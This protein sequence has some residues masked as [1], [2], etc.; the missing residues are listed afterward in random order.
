M[1]ELTP[2]ITIG[3]SSFERPECAER[4]VRSIRT[5][6]RCPIIIA[7]DSSNEVHEQLRETLQPVEGLTLLRA[8]YDSGL[9]VKRNLI[10]RTTITELLCLC[11]DDFIFTE[12]TD[13]KLLITAIESGNDLAAG[14]VGSTTPYCHTFTQRGTVMFEEPVDPATA[15]TWAGYTQY[16]LLLNFFVARVAA[17]EAV[18]WDPPLKMHE[19]GD[20]FMR[21][22]HLRKT[23]VP[24][25]LVDHVR[26]APGDYSE[27]RA[28]KVVNCLDIRM[29]RLL[30]RGLTH[31]VS[32]NGTRIMPVRRI[33]PRPPDR[34]APFQHVVARAA[35][36]NPLGPRPRGPIEA[37]PRG[38]APRFDKPKSPPPTPVYAP[39]KVS[40][41]P[42]A[43]RWI[44]VPNGTDAS[45]APD[46]VP[47]RLATLLRGR[48]AIVVG[49]APHAV[50]PDW[51]ENDIVITAN[52]G[53]CHVPEW[54]TVVAVITPNLLGL[55][56]DNF[57]ADA[58]AVG[59]YAGRRVEHLVIVGGGWND[60]HDP[61]AHTWYERA[62]HDAWPLEDI[63][64]T[65]VHR[66]I[67]LTPTGR[68]RVMA[69][70]TG[71]RVIH[72]AIHPRNPK[73]WTWQANG[74]S[75][76]IV[77]AA[78]AHA[79]GARSVILTGISLSPGHAYPE[80]HTPARR[81]QQGGDVAVLREAALR[82]PEWCTTS[83]ELSQATGLRLYTAV[84]V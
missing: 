50:L 76:G 59:T 13:L 66:P 34:P 80:P 8:P 6:Y 27:H 12:R 42:T 68:D 84:E 49:S 31:Y 82:Q 83:E 2:G 64:A 48:R 77:A 24:E 69:N 72:G 43:E 16:E 1:R 37:E 58:V 47:W 11:D 44:G 57:G 26:D 23:L 52:G 53:M 28:S 19:H 10:V 38:D 21:L 70:V 5:Y 7:D 35:V 20:W 67:G 36:A 63:G 75:T 18:P 54:A 65:V 61:L 32:D 51:E 62:E 9:S 74:W 71:G 79:C 56:S 60:Y 45:P 55:V 17:I 78:I 41:L 40:D 25:C 3:I 39:L 22:P 14:S 4:L 81:Y 30:R 73:T 46:P 15:P 29:E 33:P